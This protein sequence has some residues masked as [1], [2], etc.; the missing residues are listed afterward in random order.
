M[1]TLVTPQRI[2]FLQADDNSS[3]NTLDFN[4]YTINSGEP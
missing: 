1:Q 3:T 4:Q 2:W